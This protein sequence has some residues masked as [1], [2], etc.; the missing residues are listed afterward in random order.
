MSAHPAQIRDAVQNYIEQAY[1]PVLRFHVQKAVT[2][3]LDTYFGAVASTS[4]HPEAHPRPPPR[5]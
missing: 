2:D 5:A 1:R 4:R 3:R